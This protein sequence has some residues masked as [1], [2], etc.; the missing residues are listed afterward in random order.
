VTTA[1]DLID[2]CR[3]R[4]NSEATNFVTDVEL[5][6]YINGALGELD[7]LLIQADPNFKVTISEH[8]ITSDGY[9]ALPS[10]FLHDRGVDK[11][12]GSGYTSLMPFTQQQRNSYDVSYPG[13]GRFS[14]PFVDVYYQIQNQTC[15]IIPAV[16]APGTYRL[17]YVPRFTSLTVSDSLPSYMDTQS[18]HE[19][20]VCDVAAKIMVKQ[21]LAPDAQFWLGLKEAQRQRVLNAA[22]PRGLGPPKSMQRNATRRRRFL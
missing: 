3:Y 22:Q 20:V 16:Q 4:T 8:T 14:Y 21:D 12:L 13:A 17:H 15:Q 18:W 10:D 9:F 1:Q 11:T 19:F 2:Q 6:I 7:D 5:L